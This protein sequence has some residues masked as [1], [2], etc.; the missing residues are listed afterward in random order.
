MPQLEEGD[1]QQGAD[2]VADQGRD[3]A[4]ARVIAEQEKRGG[5]REPAE[6]AEQAETDCDG[7]QAHA[8]GLYAGCYEATY[9]RLARTR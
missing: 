6:S 4:L 5:D 2:G 8:L 1:A 3:E 7:K 9:P